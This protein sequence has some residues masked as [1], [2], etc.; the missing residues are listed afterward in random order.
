M[1]NITAINNISN[2]GNNISN[3]IFEDYT[4]LFY[5]NPYRPDCKLLSSVLLR[6]EKDYPR[7]H[8]YQVDV[9]GKERSDFCYPI[10]CI[11]Y[12]GRMYRYCYANVSSLYDLIDRIDMD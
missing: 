3:M 1:I 2:I 7:F 10:L 11:Y 8:F 9:E 12:R 6:L 4:V 5:C